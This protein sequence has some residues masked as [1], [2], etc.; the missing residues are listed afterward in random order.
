M[1][2]AL[3]Q[4]NGTADGLDVETVTEGT[5]TVARVWWLDQEH[6]RDPLGAETFI[7][8]A[9]KWYWQPKPKYTAW[10]VG[11]NAPAASQPA[12]ESQKQ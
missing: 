2:Y 8:R 5:T 3:G 10:P 12:S 4:M 9:E 1:P 7:Q 6:R 11:S